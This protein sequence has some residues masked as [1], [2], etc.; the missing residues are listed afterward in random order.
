MEI[1]VQAMD[2]PLAAEA[3]RLQWC[4]CAFLFIPGMW[5]TNRPKGCSGQ[6]RDLLSGF[7]TLMEAHPTVL[8][9]VASSLRPRPS[10]PRTKLTF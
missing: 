1:S 10:A 3:R 2:L 9:Y 7:L 6:R 4:A 5:S 8:L